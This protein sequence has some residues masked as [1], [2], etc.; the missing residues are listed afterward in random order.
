MN[1][2]SGSVVDSKVVEMSFDN[3]QFEPNAEKSLSTIEKLKKALNFTNSTDG[4]DDINSSLKNINLA[5]LT[6]GVTTLKAGFDNLANTVGFAAIVRY[7]NQALDAVER[8]TKSMTVD[9]VSAGWEKYGDKTTSVATLVAQGYEL[10]KVNSQLERLNWFTDETSYN[11]TDMVS[12]IAKF[13]ATGQDLETSV[14][15]MEGIA[16]WAALSGQNATTA[17]H[18]MYQ[19]SQAMGAGVMRKEDYMSIQNVS[20]D[21]DEFR[22]KA[23][24]AAIALGTLKKTGEDTYQSLVAESKAG[25]EEFSKSQF[26]ESLTQ[27][28]WFNKDV[29]MKVFNDYSA[30]VDQIYEYAEE[31]GITASE[32]MAE[33]G[34]QFDAFGVKAFKAAQEART[35]NDV[36]DSVKDATSTAFMNMFEIIFGDYEQATALWTSMANGLYDVVVEPIN[37]FNEILGDAFG[38]ADK[39]VNIDEWSSLGLTRAQ[40]EGLAFALK[41]VAEANGVAFEPGD[42]NSFLSSLDSGWLKADKLKEVLE[43]FKGGKSALEDSGKSLEEFHEAAM[44]VIKGG[45]DGYSS[46]MTERFRQLQEDGFDPQQVQD[47]VNELHKLAG[48]TWDVTDAILA[49]ADA[50]LNLTEGLASKSDEE[51]LAMGYTQDQINAL[52]ELAKAAEEPKGPLDELFNGDSGQS[53]REKLL[54][55]FRIALKA[56]GIIASSVSDAF[57]EIF[58][59]ATADTISGI[60]DHING[61]ARA[62]R[63]FAGRNR[64][65]IKNIF[66]GIFSAIDLVIRVI[67]TFVG[68][69]LKLL[70]KGLESVGLLKFLGNVG[71]LIK[72]FRDWVV[73]NDLIQKS[74]DTIAG[75]ITKVVTTVKGWID[76]FLQIP[77]VQ[78]VIE[79]FKTAFKTLFDNFGPTMEKAGGA[80][81]KFFGNFWSYIKAL[82]SG[83]ISF[84]DFIESVK[85]A[86]QQLWTDLGNI[87][88]FKAFGDAFGTLKD[89]ILGKISD[90][91]GAVGDWIMN[92]RSGLDDNS[93]L[94]KAFDWIVEKVTWVKDQLN[95]FLHGD[96]VDDGEDKGSIFDKLKEK[97]S[98]KGIFGLVGEF[99]SNAIGLIG[100]IPFGKILKLAPL[101]IAIAGFIKV[102]K[103]LAGIFVSAKKGINSIGSFFESVQEKGLLATLK[104]Q[105]ENNDPISKFE[106]IAKAF[107]TLAIALGIVVAAVTVLSMIETGA[108]IKAVVA[109]AAI[110]G[111][112]VGIS[113]LQSLINS[114]LDKK[115][116]KMSSVLA[117]AVGVYIMAMALAKIAKI[118]SDKL[119]QSVGVLA[120]L[121]LIVAG[122]SL[123]SRLSGKNL[124]GKT[125]FLSLI[126]IAA[127]VYI[128]A[129]ALA[130]IADI[131]PSR[132]K[133]SI[134]TLGLIAVI[135]GALMVVSKLSAGGLNGKTGFLSLIGIAASVYILALALA[136]IADIKPNRLQDSMKA[137]GLIAVIFGALVVV[138]KLSIGGQSGKTGFLSLIGIAAS[139]YILALALAKI[140]DIEPSRLQAATEAILLLGVLFAA[141]IVIDKLASNIGKGSG[142]LQLVGMAG[143]IFILAGALAMLSTVN[144]AN[145]QNATLCLSIMVGVFAILMVISKFVGTVS[146]TLLVLVGVIAVLGIVLGLLS[147]LPTDNVLPTALALSAILLALSGAMAI[148]ALLGPLSAGIDAGLIAL[149]KMI[150]F[151]AVFGVVAGLLGAL[152]DKFPQLQ[153][154]VD[155]G[156][157]LLVSIANGLGRIIGAFVGGIAEEMSN[158][159]PTI[160]ENLKVFLEKMQEA[161]AIGTFDFGPLAEAIAAIA[162][163]D[164]AGLFG[165]IA[166]L[167]NEMTEGKSNVQVFADDLAALATSFATYQTTMDEV[168]GIEI[169]TTPLMDAL[170]AI[171]AISLFEFL[172]TISNL[173]SLLTTKQTAVETFASDLETLATSFASYATTMETVNGIEIDTSGLTDIVDI[174]GGVSLT[175][176]VSA[177]GTLLSDDDKTA[178]ETFSSDLTTLA[179]AISEWD[180]TMEE[181]GDIEID[182]EGIQGVIDAVEAVPKKDLF[183]A[184]RAF[185][186]VEDTTFDDF[187][188][189]SGK[190]G[191]AITAFSDSL[192]DIDESKL[193]TAASAA[194]MIGDLGLSLGKIDLKSGF[195]S[196]DTD[197]G[198]FGAALEPFGTALSN[199]AD[200]VTDADKAA[201]AAEAAKNLAQAGQKMALMDLTTGDLMDEGK[202]T[203]FKEHVDKLLEA[204]KSA[205]DAGANTSGVDKTVDAVNKLSQVDLGDN[206]AAADAGKAAGDATAKGMEESASSMSDAMG[207][208]M[209]GAIDSI[210]QQT[211]GFEEAG[212]SAMMALAAGMRKAAKTVN[213]AAKEIA[214]GGKDAIKGTRDSYKTAGSYVSHGFSS[215]I[216]SVRSDVVSAANRIAQAAVDAIKAKIKS[217]SPSKV[218]TQL[219]KY[220]GQG[221]VNGIGSY[222]ERAEDAG[223]TIGESARKGLSRAVNTLKHIITDDMDSDPVIRPVLDLS[224]IQNGADSIGAMLNTNP[225]LA[226]AGNMGAINNSLNNRLSPNADIL[227]ALNSLKG[228]LNGGGNTYIIDGMTYDDGSNITSAVETLFRA[229]R[230]ERRM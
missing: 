11:F 98:F 61:L 135:F 187:K 203:A 97:F 173:A 83:E 205:N 63:K 210:N 197:F 195:F 53:G 179:D 95:G 105:G 217:A 51:L 15:A 139:V 1:S 27:G 102:V 50:N 177:L 196:G 123:V 155:T 136:K 56:I 103:P 138:S 125:K 184:I 227:S 20:M 84:S 178:V 164:F 45:A 165:S 161:T 74:F 22:Q 143:A 119:W 48:G 87:D 64:N 115:N 66:L 141:L 108:L 131:K 129:L 160:A 117:I 200:N 147:L 158:S 207:T 221:F 43:G 180:T 109:L 12:N 211:A 213:N 193:I 65:N 225:S 73:E 31:K 198:R 86:F 6:S 58:P 150:G 62:F 7:T 29:M 39:I 190:L 163:I 21:T 142:F 206:T 111:I 13:T 133:S 68:G 106:R 175:G 215:G 33:A 75:A 122:L 90:A 19:L 89:V 81:S 181:I 72:R 79:S 8:L 134:I 41:D 157:E 96:G 202:V 127:A 132:L 183:D 170:G 71:E 168:D 116:N 137:L 208:A 152:I 46:D 144:P 121:A 228:S 26:A 199:F 30:A 182:S 24:D 3:S 156:I 47:Y 37:G 226:V 189:N 220:F 230:K 124:K 176:L 172:N 91:F 40:A 140:A 194:K 114:K 67:K 78:K 153:T 28:Q 188:T 186:G 169:D 159:L 69:G 130:K 9:Q 162:L 94:A 32:A 76:A 118:K 222:A 154:F 52:R 93:P 70:G 224:E 146:P 92:W 54:Q 201:E 49:E 212:T 18:A 214:K 209:S 120:I 80:F 145:L 128:L 34:D 104:G 185:F 57:S 113:F 151:I 82:S 88:A 110:G 167:V 149:A 107:R 216:S 55:A 4:L 100:K 17:S 85:W 191:E 101:A 148:L 204:L 219:G 99:V 44:K 23:I 171:A 16:N 10:D 174:M 166:S 36:V 35:W 25:K 42:M 38:T 77:E 229:A 112:I 60:I 218:T 14:T 2:G 59:P 223:S 5:T 126:G 192:G